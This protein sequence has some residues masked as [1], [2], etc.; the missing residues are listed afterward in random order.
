MTSKSDLPFS[1]RIDRTY[2]EPK[3]KLPAGAWDCHF[4]FIGPQSQFPLVPERPFD[5]LQFEDT[6]FQDWELMQT[7]L[8][9]SRGLHV[10]SM[11]YGRNY[12]L[13][14][15]AACRYQDRIKTVLMMPWDSITDRE[16]Q[17]LTD[18]GVVGARISWMTEK[19]INSFM[20]DRLNDFG[21]GMH[22]LIPMAKLDK[23]WEDMIYHSPGKFVIEHN[24]VPTIEKGVN[25]K[26][27]D[28]IIKCLETDRCWV[29][30]SPRFS[31]QKNFP[32]DDTDPFVHKLVEVAP[33][34]LLW[35]S[36]WPHPQ[37][38]KPMPNDV[39]LLDMMLEWVPDEKIRNMIFVDNPEN[40]FGLISP[41]N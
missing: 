14:L 5:H 7:G 11:M 19:K 3:L 8:G 24:G 33:H 21:W 31:D 17:I 6:S 20:I 30:L 9:L 36:D 15:H 39:S 25:S 38:F 41:T 40:L 22:Y 23:Q 4:H 26:E 12:E 2:P 1:P 27:F 34:R 37:Y 28:F 13:A 10:Q 18:S 16:L 35:G 29:K 32:F